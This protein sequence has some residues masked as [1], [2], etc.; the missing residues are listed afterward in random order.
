MR[1]HHPLM[2]YRRRPRQH[3]GGRLGAQRWPLHMYVIDD[4]T[5]AVIAVESTVKCRQE[6]PPPYTL[7]VRTAI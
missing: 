5:A 3:G 4:S 2:N 6:Q 1:L 7:K